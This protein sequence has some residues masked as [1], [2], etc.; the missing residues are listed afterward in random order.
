MEFPGVTYLT[1]PHPPPTRN[2]VFKVSPKPL[3]VIISF[4]GLVL[5]NAIVTAM[6]KW[7]GVRIIQQQ[8]SSDYVLTK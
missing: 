1:V 2:S 3:L 8:R 7:D 4:P 6:A 5:R